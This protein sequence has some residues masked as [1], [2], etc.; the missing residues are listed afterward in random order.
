VSSSNTAGISQSGRVLAGRQSTT[1]YSSLDVQLVT[2]TVYA[3]LDGEM[4]VSPIVVADTMSFDAIEGILFYGFSNYRLVPR[5]N[6]DFIGANV[7]LDSISVATSPIGLEELSAEQMH[8]FPNPVQKV[9]HITADAT[10]TLSMYDMNGKLILTNS[11]D[12]NANID[13]RALENGLYIIRLN[14]AKGHY[15][16]RISVQH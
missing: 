12:Q 1:A 13:V 5:N 6:N 10:G 16:A 8:Y 9:L 14:T 4:N 15:N 3:N 11:F 7:S 2:D